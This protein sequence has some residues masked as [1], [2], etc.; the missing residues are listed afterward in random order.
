[1]S[2]KKVIAHVMAINETKIEY[3]V[4]FSCLHAVDGS[5]PVLAFLV[6]A[7]EGLR[8]YSLHLP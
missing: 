3:T 4:C 6:A 8:K 2:Y 7:G 5:I 1:V